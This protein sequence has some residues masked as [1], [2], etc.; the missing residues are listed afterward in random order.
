MSDTFSNTAAPVVRTYE[1][2]AI[3]DRGDKLRWDLMPYDALTEVVAVL[4]EGA[5]KYGDRNWE[6]GFPWTDTFASMMRHITQWM[7]GENI[8][9]S[10][11][12]HMAHV[13]ANALFL[14]TFYL[15]NT[16]TD[17]RFKPEV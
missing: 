8:D 2:G 12:H 16:G 14:L 4:T 15:R 3:R 7:I 1:S 17:D 6:K 5:K 11:R 10:G 9:E 13:A